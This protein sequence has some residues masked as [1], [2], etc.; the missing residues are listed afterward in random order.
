MNEK[1]QRVVEL[2]R[3]MDVVRGRRD[4]LVQQL[5][6]EIARIQK[7]LTDLLEGVATAAAAPPGTRP[8]SSAAATPGFP[9]AN[10]IAALASALVGSSVQTFINEAAHG[11]VPIPSPQTPAAAPASARLAPIEVPTAAGARPQVS[12]D[13]I[14]QV[15]T[16]DLPWT[17]GSINDRI[18]E[19]IAHKPDIE[20]GEMARVIY[21]ADTQNNRGKLRSAIHMLVKNHRLVRVEPGKWRMP[22]RKEAATG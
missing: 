13:A 3:R 10:P 2:V 7:Q 11:R 14:E 8:A 22:T 20:Y 4:Q 19:L 6:A 12:S 16:L 9:S 5:D 15:Q 1:L 18:V 17:Y 21:G